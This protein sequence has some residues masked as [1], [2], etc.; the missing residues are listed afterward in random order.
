MTKKAMEITSSAHAMAI[1]LYLITA[2]MGVAAVLGGDIAP[3]LKEGIG[4]SGYGVWALALTFSGLICATV[5]IAPHHGS[6][7]R[8]SRALII[9]M[10]TA[11]IMAASVS[12]YMVALLYS[13]KGP[14]TL[15][16][17]VLITLGC[18][19]RDVQIWLDLRRI[20]RARARAGVARVAADPEGE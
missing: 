12:V 19:G 16:L 11:L 4:L 3:S 6:A 20:R 18:L 9:E 17:T 15:L 5:C 7:T 10:W 13:G 2:L 1:A 8:I 14:T